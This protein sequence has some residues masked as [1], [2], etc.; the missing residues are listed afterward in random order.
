M[1]VQGRD[2]TLPVTIEHIAYHTTAVA[3]GL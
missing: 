2:S 3:R 1:V